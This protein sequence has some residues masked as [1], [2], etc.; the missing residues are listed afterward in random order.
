MFDARWF[1]APS[2]VVLVS[3]LNLVVLAGVVSLVVRPSEKVLAANGQRICGQFYGL[4]RDVRAQA[5][6][7]SAI[8]QTLDE[9]EGGSTKVDPYL[10]PPVKSFIHAAREAAASFYVYPT[11]DFMAYSESYEHMEEHGQTQDSIKGLNKMCVAEGFSAIAPDPKALGVFV[12]SSA[13]Q[14]ANGQTL[15]PERAVVKDAPQARGEVQRYLATKP[16]GFFGATCEQWA[17][18]H[19]HWDAANVSYAPDAAEW[20]V[21]VPRD[22]SALGPLV[23][24]YHVNADTGLTHGDKSN[25]VASQFAEGC[26]H[27]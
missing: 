25:D 23:I 27:Y 21:D 7:V 3:V 5:I 20:V 4:V 17:A 18:I 26:D 9:M 22:A 8:R 14:P 19:Y 10:R 6:P 24:R 1:S 16:W 15:P 13:P 11:F 2:F 12:R